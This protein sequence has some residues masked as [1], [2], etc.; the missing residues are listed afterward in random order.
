VFALAARM[1]I[2]HCFIILV[3]ACGSSVSGQPDSS[4]ATPI[5]AC[6]SV[7]TSFCA[8]MFAC[9]SASELAGFGFTGTQADCVTTE[10]AHCT[11]AAPAPG[12]CKGHA[13]TSAEVATSCATELS[14]M[15]CAM[16]KQPSSGVCKTQLC[17]P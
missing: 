17:S 6:D 11:D 8:Q 10:N 12:Y 3:A 13:Q 1:F 16:F 15:T 4:T 9:Y 5:A 14:G 2:R 7:G